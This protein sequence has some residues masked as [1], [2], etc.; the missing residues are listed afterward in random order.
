MKNNV[1]LTPFLVWLASVVI[2]FST[3]PSFAYSQVTQVSNITPALASQF[4][5]KIHQDDDQRVWE[6]RPDGFCPVALKHLQLKQHPWYN[7]YIPPDAEFGVVNINWQKASNEAKRTKTFF[8]TYC[9][10]QQDSNA[11]DQ[12]CASAFEGPI[13][14]KRLYWTTLIVK[15]QGEKQYERDIFQV[16]TKPP[17]ATLLCKDR[18]SCVVKPFAT[19]NLYISSKTDEHQRPVI[20]VLGEEISYFNNV[21][22]RLDISTQAVNKAVL[23]RV[24][25]ENRGATSA[26]GVIDISAEQFGDMDD[27]GAIDNCRIE[28]REKNLKKEKK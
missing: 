21:V 25:H 7:R 6:W 24:R 28:L 10:Y 18:P 13:P 27:L 11:I 1:A 19:E 3:Y 23:D 14:Q 4:E 15:D 20:L 2:L 17:N 22:Y 9:R 26:M 12:A 5:W 16:R 8:K